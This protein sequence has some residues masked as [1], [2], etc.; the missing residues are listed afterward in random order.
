[1]FTLII[2]G[3]VYGTLAHALARGLSLA[4]LSINWVGLTSGALAAT[5]RSAFLL[6]LARGTIKATLGSANIPVVCAGALVQP[7][8]AIVADDDGVV[9]VPTAWV[10]KIADAAA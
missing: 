2:G 4:L 8:D 5:G 10:Q 1:M 7:G 6:S 3:V 9:V